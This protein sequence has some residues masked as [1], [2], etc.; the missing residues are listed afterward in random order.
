M[1]GK[2]TGEKS[3]KEHVVSGLHFKCKKTKQLGTFR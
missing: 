2:F 1:D 3:L